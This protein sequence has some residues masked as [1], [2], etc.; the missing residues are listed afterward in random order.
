MTARYKLDAGLSRFTVQAFATGLLSMFGHNP[1][2]AVRDFSGTMRFDGGEARDMA[3]ELTARA[4]SL[5]LIDQVKA[6]DRAEIMERMRREV[7]EIAAF[8]AVT[9][10]STEVSGGRT[11]PG[12]YQVRIGGDLTLHGVTRP[13]Q[14]QG[15]LQVFVDGV[16]LR[17]ETSLR[18]ADYRIKPVSA[19]GGTIKLQDDLKLT[20]DIVGVPEGS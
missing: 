7:L 4:D 17:G 1:T 9:F 8:S 10:R 16:R 15:E 11:A 14:V 3:L 5:D 18:M 13:H 6:A 19:L 2:F 20:F 12:R